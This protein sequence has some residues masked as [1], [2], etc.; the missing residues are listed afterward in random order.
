MLGITCHITRLVFF[1]VHKMCLNLLGPILDQVTP[2]YLEL[3]LRCVQLSSE[4]SRLPAVLASPGAGSLKELVLHIEVLADNRNANLHTLMYFL[5]MPSL[6]HIST[7]SNSFCGLT[8][9]LTSHA[10][11]ASPASSPILLSQVEVVQS[12]HHRLRLLL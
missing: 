9:I 8:R 11:F 3:W 4:Q 5:P 10:N 12:L 6:M 7:P 2:L 1:D